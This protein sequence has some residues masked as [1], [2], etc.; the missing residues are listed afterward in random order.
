[1]LNGFEHNTEELSAE[2][3]K[4]LP[5]L[6]KGFKC[7]QGAGNAITSRKIIEALDKKYGMKVSDV[8]IRKFAS[9]IRI[10]RLLPGLIASSSGYYVTN[11]PAD[12]KRHIE[13]MIGRENAIRAARLALTEDLKSMTY[14]KP[15]SFPFPEASQ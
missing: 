8:Q 10:K 11:N 1:M 4:L 9:Y 2:E 13:S 15:V 12:L 6:L 14:R 5:V 7:H 3:L